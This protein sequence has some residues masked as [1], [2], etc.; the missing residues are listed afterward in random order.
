M[1]LA[2]KCI[3]VLGG[4]RSGKSCFAQ[5][6]AGK[7]GNKVLFVATGEALD[8][9]MKA[10][11][12]QHQKARPKSWRTLEAAIN[13]GKQIEK[14]IG[15]AE[16]VIIDCLT[17]LVSNVLGDEPDYERA[18]EQ[19]TTEISELVAC[20]NKLNANFVIV[21]NEVGMGL[22]PETKL[23]RTYRDLLGKANQLV[24]SHADEVY[25]MAAGIP[26]KVKG[27]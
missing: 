25:F 8:E 10:R 12:S 19:L 20:M 9:E 5:D 23:G 26:A 17:L 15:D 1:A 7:L 24:A 4:A 2:E 3:F 6:L 21:S 11:I 18:E 16:V 14:R 13:T 22:V 27:D